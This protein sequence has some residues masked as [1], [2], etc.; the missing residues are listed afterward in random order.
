MNARERNATQDQL[1]Y[2]LKRGEDGE[3]ERYRIIRLEARGLIQRPSVDL[4]GTFSPGIGFNV[5]RTSFAIS[6]IR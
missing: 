6:A 2:K 4:F 1:N 3:I 5:L